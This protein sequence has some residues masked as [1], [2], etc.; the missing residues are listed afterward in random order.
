MP[1]YMT[2]KLVKLTDFDVTP[3]TGGA[4]NKSSINTS[5][6]VITHTPIAL[7]TQPV[8]T[9]D[10]SI[11]TY[12]IPGSGAHYELTRISSTQ[13]IVKINAPTTTGVIGEAVIG[14]TFVIQ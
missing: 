10:G 5:T 12:G 14:S 3:I 6:M 8:L 13:S 7:D 4:I 1:R 11:V 9:I 2:Q